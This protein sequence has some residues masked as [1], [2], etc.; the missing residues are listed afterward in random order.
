MSLD[1]LATAVQEQVI[2]DVTIREMEERLNRA[3][4]TF[5]EE[6]KH[7]EANPQGF[8]KYQYTI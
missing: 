4:D 1:Q 8:L 6:R 2:D 7:K 5:T 3:D